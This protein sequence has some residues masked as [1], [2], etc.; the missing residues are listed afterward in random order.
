MAQVP[1]NSWIYKRKQLQKEA[2]EI[3]SSI[4]LYTKDNFVSKFIAWFL[5][6]IS[7]GTYKREQYLEEAA[8]AIAGW[9]FYPTSWSEAAVRRSL[10]HEGRHT[11]QMKILGFG[12]HPAAGLPLAVIVNLLALF[13]V[14]LAIG[15]FYME[16]DADRFSWRSQLNEYM[17]N[18]KEIE[19]SIR[20]FYMYRAEHRAQLLSGPMYLFAVPRPLARF[21]YKKMTTGL[22]N[23]T[24]KKLG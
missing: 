6:L 16:L 23:A 22:L 18:R 3:D 24:E 2:S 10:K 12:I 9:H 17:K 7:F 13:P 19:P 21:W 14:L 1:L 8:T 15:R 11:W 5:F 20:E 4:H